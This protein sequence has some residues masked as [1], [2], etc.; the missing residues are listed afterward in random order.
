[1]ISVGD[2]L[3]VLRLRDEMSPALVIAQQ[4]IRKAS[5][6]MK[7]FSQTVNQAGG[8][9]S[10][11]ITAPLVAA[12]GGA[13]M[14]AGNFQT[15]TTRL[16][17]LAGVSAEDLDVV[18]QKILD[19]APATGIGPIA[20]ATAM[21]K[22]ASTVSDAAV[23]ME[24]LEI[25]AKGAA[26][27]LGEPVAVAGALTAVINSYGAANISAAAAGDI[28]LQTVK[29]GG[30]EAAELAPTLAN[31]VPIAAQ[32][33]ITFEEVGANI[34]T[35]TKLGVPAAQA[36]TQLGAVM[37]AVLKPTKEGTDALASIGMSFDDL[38]S[39]IKE[40]GLMET[41]IDLTEKFGDNKTALAE[42]FGR[43]EALRNVMSSAGQ[44]AGTYRQVMDN[45]TKSTGAMDKAF[46][47]MTDSQGFG[48]SQLTASIQVIAITLGNALAPAM[49]K[50]I[51]SMKPVL[52]WVMDAAKWFANLNP[53]VQGVII[54]F[55][56][57]AA[58]IG[59]LLLLIGSLATGFASV[60]AIFAAPA[61]VGAGAIFVAIA[62]KVALVTAAVAAGYLI[63]QRWGDVISNWATG[64]ARSATTMLQSLWDWVVKG[65]QAVYEF[66]QPFIELAAAVGEFV[67]RMAAM[68]IVTMAIAWLTALKALM[69][70]LWEIVK[71]TGSALTSFFTVVGAVAGVIAGPFI[72]GVKLAWESFK[73][74]CSWV[75]SAFEVLNKHMPAWP[76]WAK[77]TKEVN[78]EIKNL[79]GSLDEFQGPIQDATAAL[80][81]NG[82]VTKRTI[83]LTDE[84]KKALVAAKKAQ[85]DYNKQ[86]AEQ[87]QIFAKEE[88]AVKDRIAMMDL[89]NAK[90]R[91]LFANLEKE[92]ELR[93]KAV[94]ADEGAQ[95]VL[96]ANLD[97]DAKAAMKALEATEA[98][99][100]VLFANLDLN[101]KRSMT[102]TLGAV[103]ELGN[104]ILGAIQGGGDILAA[105]GSSLGQGLAK[106]FVKN[107]GS[108]ITGALGNT[109][110]GAIN[111][112][113]PGIG[114]MLGPLMGA[115]GGKL[116]GLFGIGVNDAIK[117]A[118]VEIDK[119]RANLI[120]T[121]GPVEVLFA[122][123]RAVGIDLEGAWKHQGEA[124]K[125]AF[126]KL[127]KEFETAIAK[128]E[129][130]LSSLTSE[131][132]GVLGQARDL[133]YIFD[134]TGA[135]T[136]VSFEKMLEVA[137]KFG[138]KIESL[139]QSFQQARLQA[140]AQSVIDAFT[141]MDKGLVDTGTI[142]VG[143]KDEISRIVQESIKFGTTIPE[144]MRPWVQNLLDTG[145]LLDENGQAITDMSLIKFGAPVQTEFEKISLKIT[146]LIDKIALL[147]EKIESIAVAAAGIP[148]VPA[149]WAG[150]TAPEWPEWPEGGGDA[151]DWGGAQANGGDYMVNR[152]TLFLAGEA[153]PERATFTPGGASNRRGGT[154]T[155]I[156]VPVSINGR[157]IARAVVPLLPEMLDQ[158]GV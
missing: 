83:E 37:S 31:V 129:T 120:A 102:N 98:A 15:L 71:F 85:E 100:R 63:W 114:A 7:D 151:P 25:S 147:V 92:A 41:L 106:D 43:V 91:I 59:P 124:G 16:S 27:G 105:V 42:V 29:D 13:L 47:A 137:G 32:L 149:P 38:R 34:A 108:K 28:L 33:G 142:L 14:L 1:M 11:G 54:G 138:I 157:E 64:A 93:R 49:G 112:M 148:Q 158:M 76:S 153:G 17:S 109:L 55:L 86:V 52:Q 73:E 116:K 74:L 69:E 111:A 84:Q 94:D 72:A 19:L 96:F 89:E 58:A 18:K 122:K 70:G 150:W 50:A 107:F 113:I 5:K 103:K 62:I 146:E 39:S 110:G 44:Q 125:A 66:I 77:S 12:A 8:A 119:M 118:N 20:L 51:A 152:P 56:G 21:T 2:L 46:A 132:N 99:Q 156:T 75:T 139:G 130:D 133:G 134:K 26:A 136:G 23:G 87:L 143:M 144:N 24:I 60:I 128:M 104:T 90:Q 45:I 10:I 145:Q 36:V 117:A 82:E 79:G 22:I 57:I 3:A 123:A 67:A 115:I 81:A 141:L 101:A 97:T 35:V 48:W 68:T 40:K 95:R 155:T 80:K 9:L 121:H 88:Q 154:P 131:L 6:E 127:A 30:A 65:A 135:L 53:I 61:M 78:T 126:E 4:N 140:E